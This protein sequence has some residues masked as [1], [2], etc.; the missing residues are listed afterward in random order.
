MMAHSL[1]ELERLQ[2]EERVWSIDWHP[3]S[4]TLASVGSNKTITLWHPHEQKY[5]KLLT[6]KTE[7]TKT[8]RTVKFSHQG[9]KLVVGSFDATCSVW[10]YNG[11][12]QEYETLAVLEGHEN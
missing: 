9:D 1:V 4:K 10:V 8:I 6:L 3:T 5:K 11:E 7:H 12:S 2:A